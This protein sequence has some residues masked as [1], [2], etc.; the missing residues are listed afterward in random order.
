[1][2][3]LI[4]KVSSSVLGARGTYKL[5]V[6]PTVGPYLLPHILPHLNAQFADLQFF[7]RESS[8]TTLE[9]E[10]QDGKLDL[11]LL[12]MPLISQK[13]TVEPLFDEPLHLVLPP[14]H[15]LQR[16][17]QIGDDDLK[18]INVLTLEE[19]YHSYRQVRSLCQRLG[20]NVLKDYEGSSLDSL[21]QM[22]S[23]DMGLAFLPALYIASEITSK[24]SL[25]VK[26]LRSHQLTRTHVLAWRPNSPNRSFYKQLAKE[27]RQIVNQK[28]SHVIQ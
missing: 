5:G 17:D 8:P 21:R 3:L 19:Q 25:Q 22:V 6:S 9:K 15:E 11:L 7:V 20:A 27:V 24:G 2:D 18:D 16:L 28:L 4:D 14:N 12:P 1:M 23:M 26:Q 13:F 10:L